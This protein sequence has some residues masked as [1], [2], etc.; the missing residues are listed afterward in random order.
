[1]EKIEAEELM[2]DIGATDNWSLS[3]TKYLIQEYLK[4]GV[5][6]LYKIAETI[7]KTIVSCRSKLANLQLYDKEFYGQNV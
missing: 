3:D 4:R 5:N 1:M 6:Y 2:A 7:G